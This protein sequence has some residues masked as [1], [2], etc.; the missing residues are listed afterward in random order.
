[1]AIGC[2][3][4]FTFGCMAWGVMVLASTSLLTFECDMPDSTCAH[5][6]W[7]LIVLNF[8]PVVLLWALMGWLTFKDW[9]RK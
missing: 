6:Q 1:M 7:R 2:F 9:G 4:A 8:V 5:S 3:V